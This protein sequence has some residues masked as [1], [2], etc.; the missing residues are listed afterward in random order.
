M[1]THNELGK[2]GEKLACN[3]LLN[4]KYKIIEQNWRY[5]KAE[6][7]LIAIT[8]NTLVIVE[9]KTRTNSYFGD[10][11]DFI[12]PKKIKL[13]VSAA[14]EYVISRNLDFEVRFDIV[15]II[16]NKKETKIEHLENAFLHF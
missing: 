4:K 3:F 12:S 15:S 13:L 11:Q 7:D 10:P 5:L 9:V 16:K 8:E 2:E 1:A 14:N 6:I